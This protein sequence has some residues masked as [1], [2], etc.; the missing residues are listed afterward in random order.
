[1]GVCFFLKSSLVSL[2]IVTTHSKSKSKGFEVLVLETTYMDM[3]YVS[4]QFWKFISL[5]FYSEKDIENFAG[6][7][8][9][10]D[11]GVRV[12]STAAC[13]QIKRYNFSKL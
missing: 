13:D 5:L 6:F 11:D 1:M 12:L 4:S 8:K 7:I 10:M 3:L 2:D 9:K